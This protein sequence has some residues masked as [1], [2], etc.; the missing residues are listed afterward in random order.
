M[1]ITKTNNVSPEYS[2]QVD[3]YVDEKAQAAEVGQMMARAGVKV[4]LPPPLHPPSPEFRAARERADKEIRAWERADK[5]IGV[6]GTD[7]RPVPVECLCDMRDGKLIWAQ[8]SDRR[9]GD[10]PKTLASTNR[11][12]GVDLWVLRRVRTTAASADSSP[13]PTMLDN[14]RE[15]K[16][17]S[18]AH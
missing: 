5:E 13:G 12:G 15:E 11:G 8:P 14:R 16:S 17:D 10:R 18:R 9:V 3:L 2:R 1:Q 4:K 7:R 6:S